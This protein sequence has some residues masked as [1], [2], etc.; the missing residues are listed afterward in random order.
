MVKG[1]YQSYI[2]RDV[3]NVY[4]IET[5]TLI[6]KLSQNYIFECIGYEDGFY[7][8]KFGKINARESN[9]TDYHNIIVNLSVR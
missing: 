4:D 5:D 1:C 8:T 3:V 9:V 2:C 6:K 7:I